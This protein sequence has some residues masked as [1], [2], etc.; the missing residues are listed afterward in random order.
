MALVNVTRAFN[1]RV[2]APMQLAHVG[3]D[4][5]MTEHHLASPSSSIGSSE[6]HIRP[7][8]S[9]MFSAPVISISERILSVLRQPGH[10]FCRSQYSEFSLATG[11]YPLVHWITVHE[12]KRRGINKQWGIVRFR[13]SALQAGSRSGQPLPRLTGSHHR[14]HLLPTHSPSTAIQ[15]DTPPCFPTHEP[16]VH[17]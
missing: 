1:I 3:F 14:G 17:G 15:A 9:Q 4:F 11:F 7:H 2:L 13:S 6:I 16:H 12:F 8:R 5:P 10:S